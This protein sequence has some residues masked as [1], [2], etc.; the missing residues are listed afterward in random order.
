MCSLQFKWGQKDRKH[1]IK[2]LNI[3]LRPLDSS[4][5]KK[6]K[7]ILKK[8]R[9]EDIVTVG[10]VRKENILFTFYYSRNL[11]PI[12]LMNTFHRGI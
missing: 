2:A 5:L 7:E 10:G 1:H 4:K 6:K 12:L 3:E 11:H 9:Q 8:V